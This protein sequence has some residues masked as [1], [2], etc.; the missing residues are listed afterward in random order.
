M[1]DA[2]KN[3]PNKNHLFAFATPAE[4]ASI[5]PEYAGSADDVTSDKLIELSGNRGYACVLGLGIVSFA[6]N[7]TYLISSAKQQG[8]RISAVFIL[9]VCGAYPGRGINVLDVVRIDSE[10]VGDMGYQEKDGSFSPFPSS[11]RATAVEHAPLHLQK[12]KSAV[13]LTVNCCTGT[14]EMG[15]AR[16]KM[17]DADIENMEGAAGISACIAHN[18]P[19]FEIR[20]VSN[21]AS[22]RDRASWKFNEALAALRQAVF[23]EVI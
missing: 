14:E 7:L 20:A 21:I 1:A 6:T 16:S 19:V 10:C 13:G 17:F 9:G 3:F 18:T 11:V 2:D 5:F 22:T 8:I 23:L 4:F 15:Y 12:L